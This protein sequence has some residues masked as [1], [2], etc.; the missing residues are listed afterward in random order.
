MLTLLKKHL[1]GDLKD[2]QGIIDEIN[3]ATK[4]N[5]RYNQGFFKSETDQ[6]V[7]DTLKF[8]K[9]KPAQPSLKY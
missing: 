8:L 9:N 6:I 7:K 1:S 5:K 4:E 3:A 2:K